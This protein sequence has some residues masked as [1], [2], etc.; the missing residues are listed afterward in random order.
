M[1]NKDGSMCMCVD[2]CGLNAIT[3]KNKYPMPSVDK[4][5]DQL[6]GATYFLKI[7]LHFGYQKV[8]INVMMFPK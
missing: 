4:L 1:K 2:Y 6:K 8:C 3:I 7:D 5:F